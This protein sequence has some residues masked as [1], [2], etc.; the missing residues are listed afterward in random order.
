V[1][2]FYRE[3][4]R[5]IT[6]YGVLAVNDQNEVLMICRRHTISLL[7][8]LRGQF[9]FSNP[10][11]IC[12]LI[13]TL[14]REEQEIIRVEP[15]DQLWLRCFCDD[16]NMEQRSDY[17]LGERKWKQ[18][19]A[20]WTPP[21]FNLDPLPI[22]NEY[23]IIRESGRHLVTMHPEFAR[24]RML[25]TL[26]DTGILQVERHPS[27]FC[28]NSLLQ[29]LPSDFDTPEWDFPKGRKFHYE[30]G[31]DGAYR[32]FYEETGYD[33]SDW[34]ITNQ[35]SDE[36]TSTNQC[37]YRTDYLVCRVPENAVHADSDWNNIE[38]CQVKWVHLQEVG[39]RLRHIQF[40]KQLITTLLQ[41]GM[42]PL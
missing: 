37:M 22:P 18:L 40:S 38:V 41:R 23:D 12:Y 24:A 34:P 17:Q 3:C 26:R 39:K 9:D 36:Y 2:H 8:L 14:T 33:A 1:G 6:S 25:D 35:V 20:G 29:L 30:S 11:Q 15:F 42:L 19:Y 27:V 4:K 31:V 28:L 16:E 10:I 5:P 13:K 7:E 32:E 21:E